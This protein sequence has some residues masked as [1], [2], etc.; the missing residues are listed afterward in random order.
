MI[1]RLINFSLF[2]LGRAGVQVCRFIIGIT[3]A[4]GAFVVSASASVPPMISQFVGVE[5]SVL[6]EANEPL[7]GTDPFAHEFGI[8]VVEGA[9]VQIIQVTDGTI[10]P[11]QM[12]GESDPRNVVLLTTRIGAGMSP[13]LARTGKFATMLAPRPSGGTK[14]FVRVYNT[15]SLE[16]ASFYGDSDIFTVSSLENSTFMANVAKTDKPL[17]G[18]DSDNDGL[19]NSQEESIGSDPYAADSDGDN[20]SD[21]DEM[22]AGTDS[23]NEDSFLSLT[24]IRPAGPGLTRVEWWPSVSGRT[25]KIYCS[26]NLENGRA[27]MILASIVVS[28]GVDNSAILTNAMLPENG[29]LVLKVSK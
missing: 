9:L 29:A 23:L 19:S 18:V 27:G 10:Y 8:P 16:D 26:E 20:F 17:D 4:V 13:A 11:P 3:F 25:Y 5:S 2:L 15:A 1:N 21:A 12:N 22:V 6:N 7:V 24:S 14:I 28:T